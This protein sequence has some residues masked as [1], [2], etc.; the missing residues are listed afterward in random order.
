MT[1]NQLSSKQCQQAH[2]YISCQHC[3]ME[4]VC[5]PVQQAEQSLLLSE[6]YLDKRIEVNA[7][8]SLFKEDEQLSA[9]YAVCSGSFKLYTTNKDNEK[10]INFRFPGELLGEDA[11]FPQKYVCNAI[12]L[13]NSSVCKVSVNE[14]TSHAKLVPNLQ[15]NLVTLLSRQN[16]FNQQEFACLIAKK[17]AESLLSAFLLNMNQR[18]NGKN[19]NN[20]NHLMLSMSRENIANF[21]GLRRETLSRILSKFQ[22]D[23]LILLNGKNIALIE[24]QKLSLL[25][26]N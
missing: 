15:A 17:T 13:Q 24:I 3:A 14:L 7:G 23:G 10:I 18:I 5:Q 12:A 22:K 2:N 1:T 19:D 6:N 11:L 8:E 9:I 20:D 4:P 26:N 25:A 21:L 16:Y